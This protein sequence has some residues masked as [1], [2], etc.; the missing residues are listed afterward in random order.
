M[1][2]FVTGAVAPCLMIAIQ[3]FYRQDKTIQYSDVLEY[4]DVHGDLLWLYEIC[5]LFDVR[6]S[7]KA[8]WDI[9]AYSPSGC[10]GVSPYFNVVGH[11]TLVL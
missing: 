9:D 8:S 2:V 10:L 1:D 4:V 5:L 7:S 6:T 11:T 3:C